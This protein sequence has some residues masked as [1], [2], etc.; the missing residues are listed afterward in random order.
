MKLKFLRISL[1]L[2]LGISLYG[3]E[4]TDG[5]NLSGFGTLGI[6]TNDRDDVLYRAYAESSL[7]EKNEFDYQT[8]N[9]IGLQGKVDILDSLSVTAQGIMK[10]SEQDNWDTSLQ[11]AYLQYEMLNNLTFRAGKFRLPIFQTTELTYVGYARTW[12]NPTLSFYGVS[13]F[14]FMEGAQAI[15]STDLDQYTFTFRLNYGRSDDTLPKPKNP[16]ITS[17]ELQT[18]NIAIASMKVQ[19]DW[20]WVNVAYSQ[21]DEQ[22]DTHKV[23]GVVDSISSEAKAYSIEYSVDIDQLNLMGGFAL[24]YN[25]QMPDERLIYQSI[26]YRIDKFKPFV[27]Y[28]AKFFRDYPVAKGPMAPAFDESKTRD[29]RLALGCR[30]DIYNGFALKYQFDRIDNGF[31]AVSTINTSGDTAVNHVHTLVLDWMF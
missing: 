17:I 15:Y 12:A 3:A 1:F 21:L 24:A 11:W 19:N 29:K 4:L 8:N 2:L 31:S 27:L 23:S 7:V 16:D 9:I 20:F 22:I 6:S 26:S 10:D 18:D 30:Y 5:V 13:G 25:S 28:S 14:E